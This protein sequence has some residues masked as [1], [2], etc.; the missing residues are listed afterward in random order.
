ML[1]T[2]LLVLPSL[3]IEPKNPYT[4]PDSGLKSLSFDRHPLFVD[5][6]VLLCAIILLAVVGAGG[7][8]LLWHLSKPSWVFLENVW[9]IYWIKWACMVM[10]AFTGQ[11]L[12]GFILGRYL[13]HVKPWQVLVGIALYVTVVGAFNNWFIHGDG[14]LRQN[15]IGYIGIVSQS[16]LHL[17]FM[18]AMVGVGCLFGRRQ[19]NRRQ[20]NPTT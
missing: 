2:Y 6:V 8:A 12:A 1:Q 15:A 3:S 19:R 18:L 11:L 16:V 14:G 13:S 9:V 10:G 17:V 5:S 4:P 20:G 7:G